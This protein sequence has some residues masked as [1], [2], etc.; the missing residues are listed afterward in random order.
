[1]AEDP[2]LTGD[3]Y[4]EV[5]LGRQREYITQFEQRYNVK[6]K[7]MVPTLETFVR[8]GDEDL[9]ELPPDP[10]AAPQRATTP[11][12]Y[13]PA[14]YWRSRVEVLTADMA[15]VAG[16]VDLGDP[17]AAR[18]EGIGRAR[19]A[20]HNQR[21]DKALARYTRLRHQ[22]RNAERMLANAEAREVQQ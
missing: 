16:S 18:G 19:A 21:A 20:R 14:S 3:E 2:K 13:R 7:A 11:R 17:A 1:M 4:I 9:V 12:Y 8:A 15:S 5:L 6:L 10:E 22:L